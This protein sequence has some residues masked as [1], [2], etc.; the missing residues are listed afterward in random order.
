MPVTSH[1]LSPASQTS[2]LTCEHVKGGSSGEQAPTLALRAREVSQVNF[3]LKVLQEAGPSPAG[4]KNKNLPRGVAMG[5]W[6]QSRKGTTTH[7][8]GGWSKRWMPRCMRT[9]QEGWRENRGPVLA[10][11]PQ[12]HN[13]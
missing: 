7:R 6:G 5:G 12:E 2:E 11:L 4:R 1:S 10:G 3:V 13:G 9:V 8:Q